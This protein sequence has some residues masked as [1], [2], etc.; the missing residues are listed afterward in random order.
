MVH[1]CS[2]SKI[3]E[4]FFIEPTSIHFIKEIGRRISLAPTSVRNHIKKLEK[5]GMIVRKKAKPFNG[6]VANREND[7]FLFYKRVYNLYSLRELSKFLASFYYPE[8]V[9]V[10]GSYSIGEDIE[11]SD[12]DII[13]VAKTKKDADL[14]EFE[15]KLKRKIHIIIRANL[16][17]IDD[18]LK[19][20]ILNGIVLHGGF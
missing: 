8:L 13:V 10:Y 17:E 19:K 20:K 16:N 11:T 3:E 2:Q 18:S 6:F 7:D 14:K 4:V 12:I 1:K 9:V 15:K 5:Q